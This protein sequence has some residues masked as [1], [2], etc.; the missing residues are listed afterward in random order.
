MREKAASR[1]LL[2][3]TGPER[4]GT[5]RLVECYIQLDPSQAVELKFSVSLAS[6]YCWGSVDVREDLDAL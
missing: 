3:G 4:S 1:T 6:L 2:D 5:P